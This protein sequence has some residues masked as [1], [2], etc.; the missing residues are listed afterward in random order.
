MAGLFDENFKGYGWED[1]ELGYRL[2]Q[3]RVPLYY[4]PSAANFHDH[5]VS[6]D[7]MI[8]RKFEMGRSAALFLR[9]HPNF[10]VK[11]FIGMNPL[12]MGIF[13]FIKKRPSWLERIRHKAAVSNFFRYLLEEYQ[14]RL[15]LTEGLSK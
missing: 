5:P 15:G 6:A 2:K 3:M 1:I 11:M 12:A 10:E 4:L 7:G 13:Y 9:K 8:E 14:Y